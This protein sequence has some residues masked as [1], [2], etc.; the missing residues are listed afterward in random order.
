MTM[1]I[2][3][4]A[5]RKVIRDE[6]LRIMQEDIQVGELRNQLRAARGKKLKDTGAHAAKKLGVLGLKGALSL[7]PG[8]SFVSDAIEAGAEIKDLLDIVKNLKPKEKESSPLWD[9]LTIDPDVSDIL[10][11]G[12]EDKFLIDLG[13]DIESLPD[14]ATLPDADVQLN[15]WLKKNYGGTQL[16]KQKN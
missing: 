12:V 4:A 8:A 3:E 2:T 1:R 5:L 7:I 9:F 11:N 6:A 10:D 13:K 16:V 15:N 14:D